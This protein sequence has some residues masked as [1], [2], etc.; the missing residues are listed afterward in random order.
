MSAEPRRYVS[1]VQSLR[2]MVAEE[3]FRSLFKGN[4]ANVVRVIPAYGF[5]HAAN[6]VFKEFVAPGVAKPST[7][8]MLASGT[9]VGVSQL[10]ISYPL[11]VIRTR[12][13][14]GS[15]LH[16]PV[17]YKGVLHCARKIIKSEGLS[18]TYVSR[19]ARSPCPS[20]P[21]LTV[22]LMSSRNLGGSA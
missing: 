6:D 4:G 5:K 2:R 22:N 17:V 3:G 13:A 10:L 21:A 18:A 11:E 14:V 1:I 16:P 9:L 7:L 12:M 8:Q 19:R 15:S 20:S